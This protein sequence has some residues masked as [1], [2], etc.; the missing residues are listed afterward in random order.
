MYSILIK[1]NAA[2]GELPE[3]SLLLKL[4]TQ[5]SLVINQISRASRLRNG[6]VQVVVQVLGPQLIPCSR[7]T[8]R[9]LLQRSLHRDNQYTLSQAYLDDTLTY[10]ASAMIAVTDLWG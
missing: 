10:S 2:V 6:C 4:Y 8:Y 7:R 1:V 3:R 9:R 5:T